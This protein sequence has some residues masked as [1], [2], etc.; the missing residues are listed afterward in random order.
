MQ[1]KTAK[2]AAEA[3][4]RNG[5]E[6]DLESSGERY[7][8]IGSRYLSSKQKGPLWM[9]QKRRVA[10]AASVFESSGTGVLRS[11]RGRGS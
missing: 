3:A 2:R 1:L 8:V 11:C 9:R 4:G 7:S 5:K 10:R 6:L